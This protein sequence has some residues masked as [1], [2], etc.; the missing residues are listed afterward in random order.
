MGFRVG[1][2]GGKVGSDSIELPNHAI[3]PTVKPLFHAI[4]LFRQY[5]MPF[6][7][8]VQFVLEIF[9]LNAEL[10]PELFFDLILEINQ[11]P[12]N[13][14][15][16]RIIHFAPPNF[17]VGKGSKLGVRSLNLAFCMGGYLLIIYPVRYQADKK[18]KIAQALSK[19][20]EDD[21]IVSFFVTMNEHVP[22][23]GHVLERSQML[24]RDDAIFMKNLEKVPISLRL[25]PTVK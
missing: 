15:H 18:I 10:M 16:V 3:D 24:L 1:T 19:E 12:L 23:G 9:R 13:I 8:K 6:H 5:L 21:F 14:I 7:N 2:M 22:E 20:A 25:A 17:P 11:H 4:Q